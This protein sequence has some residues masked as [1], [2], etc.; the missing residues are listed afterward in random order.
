MTA[1]TAL[2]DIVRYQVPGDSPRVGLRHGDTVSALEGV[3]DIG[4]LL[5]LSLDEIVLLVESADLWNAQPTREVRLLPPISGRGEVWCSGVTYARS[6]TARVEESAQ[7]SIYDLVYE[8]DRP[9]LFLKA[10]AWRAVTNGDLVGI[11]ADSGHDVPDP[12]LA[13][14]ANSH[15]EIVGYT[16][17][18]DMSSRALE[19]QNPLYLPQAKVFAGSCALADAIR[20]AWLVPSPCDLAIVMTIHRGDQEVFSGAT[21]TSQIVRPLSELVTALFT[22]TDFPDGVILATG[23]GIVPE[24]DFTLRDGDRVRISISGVGQLA[25]T[26]TVGKDPFRCVSSGVS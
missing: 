7:A 24:M 15:G 12:E 9:E 26:V 22:A 17:C 4:H 20:P 2:L 10:P 19:G 13:V 11:R 1:T 5:R 21:S 3:A 23:T 18:N 16:I 8:A 6:R 25:N 14:V